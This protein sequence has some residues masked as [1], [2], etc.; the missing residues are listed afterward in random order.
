VLAI[1]DSFSADGVYRAYIVCWA[2]L[3]LLLMLMLL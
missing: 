1:I 3:L 2:R